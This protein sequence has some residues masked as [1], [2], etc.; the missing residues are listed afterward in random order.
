M[1]GRKPRGPEIVRALAG[2]EQ[3]RQRLEAILNT[4]T[5][6]L[7]FSAA[8]EQLGITPQRLHMLREQALQAALEALA[9]QPMGRPAKSYGSDQERID[10][11]QRENERLQRELAA[12]KLREEIALVLSSRPRRGEKKRPTDSAS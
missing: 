12:S 1:Q 10:A 2:G 9:P 3:E 8:A 5:G 6:Q 4:L 11:L 7:G